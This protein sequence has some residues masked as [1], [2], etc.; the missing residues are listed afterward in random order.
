MDVIRQLEN[1]AYFIDPIPKKVSEAMAYVP[2]QNAG[3]LYAPEQALCAGT[4]F[5]EL[6]FPFQPDCRKGGTQNE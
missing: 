1:S 5:P 3:K 4:L 2:F 6:H